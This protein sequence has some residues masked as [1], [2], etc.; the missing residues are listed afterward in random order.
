MKNAINWFEI[1]TTDFERAV[2]FYSSI[3]EA[4]MEVRNLTELKMAL[5][6]ADMKEGVGGSLI[7]NPQFYAPS[8]KGVLIYLN[9]NPDLEKVLSKVEKF[10]GKVLIKK[11]QISSEVGFMAVFID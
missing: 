9:A 1:P 3:F 11:R 5:F 2:K 7:Y 8:D 4:K 10:G 6:P